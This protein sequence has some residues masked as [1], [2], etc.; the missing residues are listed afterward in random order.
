MLV[1]ACGAVMLRLSRKPVSIA[2]GINK[3]APASRATTLAVLS[4]RRMPRSAMPTREIEP[5]SRTAASN[6][7]VPGRI[8]MLLLAGTA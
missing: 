3:S 5:V 2:E 8:R 1:V 4:P 7:S 6:G